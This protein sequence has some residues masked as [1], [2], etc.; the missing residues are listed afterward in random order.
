MF[1]KY[2][3][4]EQVARLY[5]GENMSQIITTVSSNNL[6]SAATAHCLPCSVLGYSRL[7]SRKSL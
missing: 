3:F 7:N 4:N 1:I 6:T 2:K 5:C